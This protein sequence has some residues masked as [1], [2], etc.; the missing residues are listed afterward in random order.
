M[1]SKAPCAPGYFLHTRGTTCALLRPP[2]RGANGTAPYDDNRARKRRGREQ[3]IV[4]GRPRMWCSGSDDP[5]RGGYK[6]VGP[7]NEATIPSRDG[8]RCTPQHL[9]LRGTY[10]SLGQEYGAV[11][12]WPAD[13][14]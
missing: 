7:S 14:A 10:N 6:I 1:C 11:V 3:G 12:A 13:A 4:V 9:V 2:K 5:I 8:R